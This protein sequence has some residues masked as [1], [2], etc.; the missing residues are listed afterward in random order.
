M[1]RK[2]ET[3]KRRLA[4]ESAIKTLMYAPKVYGERPEKQPDP[5]I[6]I[7]D[8]AIKDSQSA[9]HIKGLLQLKSERVAEEEAEKAREKASTEIKLRPDEMDVIVNIA[10]DL[11]SGHDPRRLLGIKP[12]RGPRVNA[13]LIQYEYNIATY[14]W[15]LRARDPKMLTKSAAAE[16]ARVGGISELRVK[17]IARKYANFAK[18]SISANPHM[19]MLA[20]SKSSLEWSVALGKAAMAEVRSGK[21]S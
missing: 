11:L 6:G 2:S 3:E 12:K 20:L 9:E 17:K 16:V 7:I 1:S 19:D 8:S 18:E 14:F 13:D 4:F 10:I 21:H 5:F 15:G